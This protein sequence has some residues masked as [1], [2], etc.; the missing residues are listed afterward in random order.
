MAK[1]TKPELIKT[2]S[3]VGGINQLSAKAALD[4]LAKVLIELP[5]GNEISL[6]GVG[7]FVAK[8]IPAHVARNPLTGASVDV[9]AKR[10]LTFKAS[11][12]A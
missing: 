3:S 7:K 6:N 4:A 10:R 5:A 11:K 12:V 1:M 9:P 8:E 2:V